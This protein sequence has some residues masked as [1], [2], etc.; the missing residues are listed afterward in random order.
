MSRHSAARG[1]SLATLVATGA[2][3]LTLVGS[4]QVLLDTEASP[5]DRQTYPE[6]AFVAAISSDCPDATRALLRHVPERVGV[7]FKLSSTADRDVIAAAFPVRRT[8]GV[9]SFTADT[10][11]A[12]DPE[13]IVGTAPSSEAFAMFDARDHARSWLE[14]LLRAGSAFVCEL[15]GARGVSA[16]ASP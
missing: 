8:T 13:A 12:R 9:L 11:F 1:F 3:A 15:P 2:A 4:G 7:V 6:T 14:P 5:Y 10:P 16:G